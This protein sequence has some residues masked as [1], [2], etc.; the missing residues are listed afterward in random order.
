MNITK[1]LTE[2]LTG[3]VVELNHGRVIPLVVPALVSEEEAGVK[4]AVKKAEDAGRLLVAKALNGALLKAAKRVNGGRVTE[5]Y[6]KLVA[7]ESERK[8]DASGVKS[9]R[10]QGV[11]PPQK[12]AGGPA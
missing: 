9:E 2:K 10:G 12:G 7:E 8:T 6:G 11:Q 1:S 4:A 3:R 5:L